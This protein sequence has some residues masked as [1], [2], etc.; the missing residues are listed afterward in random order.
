M[1][2]IVELNM[3]DATFLASPSFGQAAPV[4]AFSPERLARIASTPGAIASPANCSNTNFSQGLS[5]FSD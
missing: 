1:D 3:A 4:P 2:I 5:A